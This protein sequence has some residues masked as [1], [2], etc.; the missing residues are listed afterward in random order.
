[1]PAT[2]EVSHIT[3][4]PKVHARRFDNEVIILDLG[5]GLYFGLDEVGAEMWDR[6]ILGDSPEQVGRALVDKYEIPE[7]RLVEDARKL[8]AKLC[9]A[10][11]VIVSS[12]RE[13][14]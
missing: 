11:L 5:R 7:E 9:D 6:F 10:G 3:L 2:T 1:M 14:P 4:A 13:L 12:E 8:I